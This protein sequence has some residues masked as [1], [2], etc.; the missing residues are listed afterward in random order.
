[1]E[2]IVILWRLNNFWVMLVEIFHY[3]RNLFLY[4]EY[5]SRFCL[6]TFVNT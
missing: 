3:F 2:L 6:E 5:K 4:G 1:M